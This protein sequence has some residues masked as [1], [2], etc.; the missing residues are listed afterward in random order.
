MAAQ[1]AHAALGFLLAND[2]ATE[3]DKLNVK[4]STEEQEWLATG[5]PKIVVKANSEDEL[6]RLILQAEFA[7]LEVNAVVDE[8]RTEFKGQRTLTC[9]AFGPADEGDINKVTGHLKL[10]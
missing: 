8:G 7:G 2:E 10:L 4:L 6:N 3:L 1:A 9:A 5:M